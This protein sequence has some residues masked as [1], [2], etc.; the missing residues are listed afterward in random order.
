MNRRTMCL[1]CGIALFVATASCGEQPAREGT[2]APADKPAERF[3]SE[4]RGKI[5]VLL[6]GM[7]GCPNTP[8]VT[9]VLAE[10]DEDC[11]DDVVFGRVDV[12]PPGGSIK[13]TANWPHD[14]FYAVDTDRAVAQRLEF[15]FY[16]TLYVLDREGEVRY[17]GGCDEAKLK[18]M[19]SEMLAEK[20]GSKKKYYT[21]PLPAVGTPAAGFTAKDI[22]GESVDLKKFQSKGATLLFFTSVD[23][24]FS[25][26]AVRKLPDIEKE[27]EGKNLSIV[28]I[29]KG[30]S[31]DAVKALYDSVALSGTV[32]LDTDGNVSDKYGV[33]PVPFYFVVGADGKIAERGPYTE[34]AARKALRTAL[35]LQ[36][37]EVRPQRSPGAG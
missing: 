36:G 3:L 5:V 7:D 19:I 6:M 29:E 24:P 18:T 13:P 28:L 8:V 11:P 14:F 10:L 34:E 15:F 33:G 37:T 31:A 23:C 20:P 9:E 4:Q 22:K 30:D 25:V 12:A 26:E 27:F 1:L 2:S 21:P 17:A 32:V 35:G 16:P